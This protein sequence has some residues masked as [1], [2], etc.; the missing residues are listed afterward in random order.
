MTKKE[1][2][3]RIKKLRTEINRHNYLYHVLD[4]PEI[5][6]AALDSI[7][8][9]LAKLETQFPDLI[10]SDSPTQRVSGKAL[11]KFPK[12]KHSVRMLSLADAFSEE[13]IKDWEDRTIKI[14]QEKGVPMKDLSYYAELKMDGL[15]ASLIYRKGELIRGATRGDGQ[16]GEDVTA[17]LR[18]ITSIPL[19]LR[20]PTEA[21]LKK[22][23]LAKESKD[24]LDHIMK[25]EVEIRGEA[26]MTNAVLAK[27]NKMYAKEGRALLANSRNAAAGSIRQLDPKMTAERELDFYCYD[28]ATDLG[29]RYHDQEHELAKLLGFK[30]PVAN[31]RCANYDELIRFHHSLEKKRSKLAFECDGVVAVV[32]DTSL[33]DMLGIVGKGP[34]YMIAYKFANEQATTKLLDVVWQVGR[35]GIL[36]PIARLA[37]VPVKGVVI[38]NATLHNFDEINRLKIKI[39][40]TVIIE[41]AGDVIPKI[42]GVL[43][44][45]RDGSEKT[46]KAPI[47][48]PIC[49]NKVVKV[50]GEVAYRC[51]N[52]NCYA[53]N[54]RRLMH[55]A[56]KS[57]FDIEGLGPKIIEQLL[58]AG[59]ISDPADFYSLTKNDL[60]GLERFAEISATNTIA[61]IASAKNPS[62]EKFI[63]ALGIT[64]VGE[65]TAIVLSRALVAWSKKKIL[66]TTDLIGIFKTIKHSDLETLPDVGVK[67]AASIVEWFANQ[68]HQIFLHKLNDA[69][70]TLTPPLAAQKGIF[71]GQSFVLTGSLESLTRD[72]AKATIRRLGG[73][74]SESVS[75]KTSYVIVGEKPGSK[76]ETAKKLGVRTLSENEFIKLVRST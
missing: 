26:I 75:A 42:I 15:A 49:G 69:G 11:S 33:W 30:S 56:S 36:T 62:L 48:C 47:I 67:V 28:I 13:E 68:S 12:V 21:E 60:L 27:L 6:D 18:T 57:A 34:R 61:A 40:D 71:S 24:I 70:L 76:Y 3:Q 54:L 58:K 66:K 22:I 4:K 45:L 63:Y 39:G 29:I 31:A 17:N 44:K 50:E 51:L 23:G 9:E 65:E 10:T 37:P 1:A 35:T 2:I 38:S 41:R 14:L 72:E 55:W 20:V 7:K 5:S 8:N 74:I 52:K 53:V 16:V 19:A 64:H 46:I 73:E 25:G 43:E 32:N 59:L